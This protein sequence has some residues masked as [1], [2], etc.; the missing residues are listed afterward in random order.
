MHSISVSTE[1][2]KFQKRVNLHLFSLQIFTICLLCQE[3]SIQKHKDAAAALRNLLQDSTR[4]PLFHD[5]FPGTQIRTRST[6][7]RSCAL[8]S[9]T[10][11]LHIPCGVI[12]GLLR[13][14]VHAA[15]PVGEV[16]IEHISQLPW[17]KNC[18][19]DDGDS[20]AVDDGIMKTNVTLFQEVWPAYVIL[21]QLPGCSYT[22]AYCEGLG[23]CLRE[24]QHGS[25]MSVSCRAL[26]PLICTI[27]PNILQLY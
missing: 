25:M 6:S 2:I 18:N 23:S 21:P 4:D 24:C 16:Q 17:T 19:N 1:T 9:W 13:Q 27:L 7:P 3:V 15:A 22:Q 10:S 12:V 26:L 14:A 11:T 8:G 5:A 20:K